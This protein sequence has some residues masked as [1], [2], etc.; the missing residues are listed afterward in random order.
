MSTDLLDELAN[1]MHQTCELLE[2]PEHRGD[3]AQGAD[4][5]ASVIDYLAREPARFD[6]ND[7]D[8][9]GVAAWLAIRGPT[10][11]SPFTDPLPKPFLGW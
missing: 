10:D 5:L 11:E 6:S 7:N 4:V 2:A 3:V 1:T 9:L 8:G